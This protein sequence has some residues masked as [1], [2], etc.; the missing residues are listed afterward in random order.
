ALEDSTTLPDRPSLRSAELIAAGRHQ[1]VIV[2]RADLLPFAS[3]TI[4]NGFQ[5]FPPLGGVLANGQPVTAQRLGIPIARGFADNAFCAQGTRLDQKCQNGGWFTDRSVTATI[6]FPLFD[7]LRAK[8]NIDL[9]RAQERVA[10]INL[11]LTRETVSLEVA[12]ARA[13]LKRARAVFE[14]RQE[15]SGQAREAFQLASLRFNRG[16]STQLEVSDAQLA[17]LTAQ[18]TEARATYDLYLSTAELARSLG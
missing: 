1:G 13:E 9:A 4:Q 18:S 7:G 6:S 10:Q 17:L 11:Q 16:L 3:V 2:A 5:A 15:N 8:S 14:A 12:R